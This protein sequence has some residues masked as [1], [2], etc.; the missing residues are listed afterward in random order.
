MQ[1]ETSKERNPLLLKI[2]SAWYCKRSP[3]RNSEKQKKH[4]AHLPRKALFFGKDLK[5]SHPA[6]SS[7]IHS[8]L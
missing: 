8:E 4:E 6:L 1:I 2:L 3:E 7:K 5:D